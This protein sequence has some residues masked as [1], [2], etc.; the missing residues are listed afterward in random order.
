METNFPE[1]S[2][3]SRV[4]NFRWNLASLE[5]RYREDED[6]FLDLERLGDEVIACYKNCHGEGLSPEECLDQ[7]LRKTYDMINKTE[8]A[9]QLL[10][11]KSSFADHICEAYV[12]TAC[13][14]FLHASRRIEG[15]PLTE[16]VKK[17]SS[18]DFRNSYSPNYREPNLLQA[19]TN[20]L[21]K[22]RQRLLNQGQV[23]IKQ[24]TQWNA[25]TKDSEYEWARYYALEDSNAVARDTD[26]RIGNLYKG[27]KEAINTDRDDKYSDR[28]QTAYKKF[29]SKLEKLKYENFLELYKVDLTRICED[30][31]Y[32]GLNLYRLERRLQPYK[33]INEVKRLTEFKSLEEEANFLLKT[34]Y[35]DEICFPKVYED[36]LHNPCDLVREYAEEVLR[37][38]RTGTVISNLILDK[39]VEE[40]AFGENWDTLF[41]NKVNKMTEKV[42]YDPKKV[43]FFTSEH[44]QEKFIRLLHAGVFIETHVACN[45]MFSIMD[46]LI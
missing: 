12:F 41:L 22:A 32:Y 31:E 5:K 35:L 4:K 6:S 24:N 8:L 9:P 37:V 16:F 33:I 38:W 25:M 10:C 26:K 44:A 45:S 21:R 17:N 30:K 18:L 29:L 23:Y 11:E 36:L 43:E 3:L 13:S 42:L 28:V 2:L 19:E 40:K 39:L 15:M 14:S 20:R 27:I 34:V 1:G 7:V 46:L